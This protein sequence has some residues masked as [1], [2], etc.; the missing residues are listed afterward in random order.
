MPFSPE[1]GLSP[2]LIMNP[3]AIPSRMT[4]GQFI[5]SVTGKLAALKGIEFD[6]S[7]FQ[8]FDLE[9]VRKELEEMGYKDDGTEELYSGITGKPMRRRIFIGPTYYMRLKHLV[10]DKIHCLTMD[11]EVLTENGWK[12]FKDIKEEEKLLTLN[13]KTFETSY[14][15]P[16]E[17]LYFEKKNVKLYRIKN[18]AIDT[19]VT[20]GHRLLVAEH[21]QTNGDFEIRHELRT[22]EE[23]IN[24]VK[25][26]KDID[27][28]TCLINTEFNNMCDNTDS[29]IKLSDITCIGSVNTDVF[30]FTMPE[31][32]FYVRRNGH[33][34]WS[35]NSRSRG[36]RTLLTHQAPEGFKHKLIIHKTILCIKLLCSWKSL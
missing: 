12:F 10:M 28:Y 14:E 16:I 9:K 29:K 34:F 2:D 23:L 5:E 15:K 7:P 4:L 30:C 18:D 11:H 3:N 13:T 31:E 35:G 25:T 32:T 27:F 19:I 1:T 17:K 33:E 22:I 21:I 6:G 24:E 36:P 8:Q 20:N 26:Y